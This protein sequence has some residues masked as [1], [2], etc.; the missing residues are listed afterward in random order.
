MYIQTLLISFFTNNLR[1]LSDQI[2]KNKTKHSAS[3]ALFCL[4][5]IRTSQQ[6]FWLCHEDELIEIILTTHNIYVWVLSWVALTDEVGKL[7][8]SF[9]G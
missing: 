8:I 6:R 7:D 2:V 4:I 1:K 3:N 5:R 9:H